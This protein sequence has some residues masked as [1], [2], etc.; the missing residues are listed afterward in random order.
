MKGKTV[1]IGG[2]SWGTA[3]AQSLA[4]KGYEVLLYVIEEGLKEDINKKHINTMYFPDVKLYKKIM[5]TYDLKEALNFSK[6]VVI[7]IPTQY[8]DE[9]MKKASPFLNDDQIIISTAKGIEEK[10]FRRNSQIIAEWCNNQVVV[11]SGP[12]H[13]EEVINGIPSAAVAAS[14]DEKASKLVQ[15]LFMSPDFRL[16][17]NFDVV[18]VE[19]AA[20]VKNIMAVAAGITDGLD[21]GD[22]TKAALITRGLAEMSRLGNYLGGHPLTFSGLAGM[23][24]LVV[25]CTSKHSRNRGFG[26]Y[27]GRGFTFDEALKKVGQVVEGVKTARAVYKWYEERNNNLDFD[28]PITRQV[29][30]VLFNGKNPHKAVDDLMLRGPKYERDKIV[31]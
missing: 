11:L 2:G 25:T 13:A 9:I 12:T 14:E 1:V 29:Y 20:A 23:G 24:D 16:Y 26:N 21:Y 6:Y 10:T 27:I 8:M 30:E 28:I 22:N 19:L 3:L 17:T 31:E 5:V 18:G 4:N 15:H 7:S